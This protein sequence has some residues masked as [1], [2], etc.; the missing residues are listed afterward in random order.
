MR[1][2]PFF[3]LHLPRTAGTTLNAIIRDTFAPQETLSVYTE[4]EYAAFRE[5]E[6]AQLDAVR[7]IQGH[8][9]LDS[10]DPPQI[11]GR[12]VAV[13]TF[14]REPVARLISEYYFLKSWPENHMYAYLNENDISFR[15]YLLGTERRLRYRGKNFMT[16]FFSGM[17]FALDAFPHKALAAAQH[18]LEHVFGCVGVQERFD[19]S[20]LLLGQFLGLKSLCYEKRNV[21]QAKS[22]P[23][24]SDED[25]ALARELNAGDIALYEMACGLFDRRVTALG[26][27]FALKVKEFTLINAKYQSMCARISEE[28]MGEQKGPVIL[29]K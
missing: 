21:L 20:L 5:I 28:L 29:P 6:A 4:Q 19:E 18:N 12:D 2:V 7:L 13:F 27:L 3:F 17:D 16:R 11:Y 26:R 24:V 1:D 9:F 14:V 10:Y 15:E 8:L 23:V 25:I 22:K